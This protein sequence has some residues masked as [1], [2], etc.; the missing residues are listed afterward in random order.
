MFSSIPSIF[1]KNEET[2]LALESFLDGES[3]FHL[4]T[5]T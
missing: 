5:S 2:D 1:E 3:I 4:G